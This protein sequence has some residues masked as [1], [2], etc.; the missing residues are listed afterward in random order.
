MSS[1]NKKLLHNQTGLG[2]LEVIIGMT[3][4]LIL[5]TPIFSSFHTAI[6]SYQYNMAQ[7]QNILA[8]RSSLNAIEDELRYSNG[9]S[10]S[11]G[12]TFTLPNAQNSEL[13]YTVGSERRAIYTIQGNSAMTNTLVIA[14]NGSVKKKINLGNLQ[15]ITIVRKTTNITITAQLNPTNSTSTTIRMSN[16]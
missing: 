15:T 4:M 7:S 8:I 3:I 10:I 13:T 1:R 9:I 5:I 11:S 16:M 14:Y 6:T 12:T 2:L